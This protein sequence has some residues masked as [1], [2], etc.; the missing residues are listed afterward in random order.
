M[1]HVEHLII[2]QCIDVFSFDLFL[3]APV[4]NNARTLVLATL[5]LQAAVPAK[6]LTPPGPP[7]CSEVSLNQYGQ[8]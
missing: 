5:L 6:E 2:R 4:G 8:W 1:V 3:S 7:L